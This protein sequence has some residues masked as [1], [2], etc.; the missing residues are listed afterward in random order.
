MRAEELEHQVFF[1]AGPI[2]RWNLTNVKHFPSKFPPLVVCKLLAKK[3]LLSVL[4]KY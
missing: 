1:L 3:L 2:T 4:Y